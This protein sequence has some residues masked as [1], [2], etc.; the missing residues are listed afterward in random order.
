MTSLSLR[1]ARRELRAGAKGF[2]VFLACIALGVAAI[3]AA[4]STAEAFR[5]GLASRSREILG[6][7]LSVTLRGRRFT[8]QERAAFA[9]LGPSTDT[10]RVNAMAQAPGGARR[11]VEVRGVDARFPLAGAVTVSGAPSLAAALAAPGPPGAAVEQ[12]LLDRLGLKL[13]DT[14]MLGEVPFAIRAV[15]LDE[16]DRLAGGFEMGP[17]V[18]ASRE[19]LERTGLISPGG[20]FVET[21]RI[22]LPAGADAVAAGEAL[23]KG[24]P[25]SGFRVRDRNDAA[26]G[27]RELIGRLE[28][29]LAFIGLAALLAGGLGVNGAVS[30][31][32]EARKPSIAVLKALGAEGP[33]VRNVFLIRIAALT[34]AGISLGLA[35]GAA[36]PFLLGALFR[37]RLEVPALFGVYPWPLIKAAVFGALA[38]AAFSLA[39]LGRARAT[40]PSS[41]FRRDLTGP[42]TLGPESLLAGLAALGLAGV[43]VATAPTP[44]VAAGMVAATAAAWGLLWLLGRGAAALAGRLRGATRGALRLGLANLAGPASAART[45]APSIGLGVALLTV[46]LLLQAALLAKVKEA[47]PDAAPALVL[48]NVTP[49]DGPALDAAIAPLIGGITPDRYRRMPFASGRIVG[50]RGGP[51]EPEQVAPEGRW[52]FDRDINLTLIDSAPPDANL[53]AGRWWPAGYDGPPMLMIDDDIAAAAKLRPGDAVTLSVLG[54]ELEARI[55]GVRKVEFGRFGASFALILNPSALAGAELTQVVLIKASA[56]QAGAVQRLLA[57]RFPAANVFDVRE[58]LEKAGELLD[59]LALAVRGAAAVVAVSGL[60]VLGGAVAATAERRTREAAILKVLGA[61]RSQALA[62]T[63]VEYGSVGLIAAA[64]GVLLGTA[65]AWPVVRF[66]FDFEWRFDWSVLTVLLPATVTLT[67]VAGALASIPALLSRPAPVLRRE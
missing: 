47:A 40:P 6:G 34:A 52:A 35:G 49:A 33:L 10:V 4:G 42:L 46:V 3:A 25:D 57:R 5:H 17:R 7:D 44:L 39:P 20:L 62:A 64:T 23:Q 22:A 60:L 21:I 18:M 51:I 2:R 12:A 13:G 29:F 50:V 19:V 59:Q 56:V 31:Y 15:L 36:T 65:A 67:A 37:D 26:A 55:A 9:S 27:L 11:L 28:Y 16:P 61:A 32:L 41:L 43:A 66:A 14:V 53:V 48:T 38:A 58:Q 45:A 24:F 30:S 63:V 8:D 54:R 1:Y